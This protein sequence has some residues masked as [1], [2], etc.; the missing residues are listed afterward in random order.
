[1]DLD[2]TKE[3][4]GAAG[5]MG[6]CHND[7]LLKYVQNLGHR[8]QRASLRDRLKLIL[9]KEMNNLDHWDLAI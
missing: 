4:V 5:T 9:V 8:L 2:T 6:K 1:V 7:K 3:W